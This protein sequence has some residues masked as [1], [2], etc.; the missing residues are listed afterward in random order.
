MKNEVLKQSITALNIEGEVKE[1]DPAL[2][3]VFLVNDDFTPMEF[4]IGVLEKF[5]SM[6]RARATEAMLNAHQYGKA[7]CGIF[8]KDVAETKISLVTDEA[9]KQELPLICSMEVA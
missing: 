2:Y 8:T 9:S 3:E 5:F 7:L 6:D 1:K 4:V